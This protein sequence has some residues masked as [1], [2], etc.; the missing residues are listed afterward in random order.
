MNMK[1]K[2]KMRYR[3]NGR[4]GGRDSSASPVIGE[5]LLIALVLILV[6]V[7]TMSLMQQLP[8]DRVPTVH[9]LMHS[10][11]SGMVSFHHKGGDY[12]R[13][14]NMEIF[15]DEV[16][17]RDSWKPGYQKLTFDLGDII[18]IPAAAGSKIDIVTRQAVIFRG[19]VPL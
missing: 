13:V 8:E 11:G 16:S 15:V 18:S 10:D 17:V 14:D 3:K 1:I 6:P 12:L 5:V 7:A 2:I 4:F 19:V 9:I